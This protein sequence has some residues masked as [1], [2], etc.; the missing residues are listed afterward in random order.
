MKSIFKFG[1]ALLFTTTFSMLSPAQTQKNLVAGV[2]PLTN[3]I[4]ALGGFSVIDLVPGNTLFSASGKQTFLNVGFTQSDRADITMVLYTTKRN[5]TVIHSVTPITFGGISSGVILYGAACG[6]PASQARP[7]V[8]QLDPLP[9]KL[10]PTNDYYFVTYFHP[11]SVNSAVDIPS[12]LNSRTTIIGGLD[13]NDDTTLV[14][15]D[16]IPST[17]VSDGHAG[18]LMGVTIQ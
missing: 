8:I 9:F 1:L 10:V 17:L 15:G 3:S 4:A 12:S 7:C 5:N 6:V 18:F 11:T 2:G 16:V 13:R 14:A